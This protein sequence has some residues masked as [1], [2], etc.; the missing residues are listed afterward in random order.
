M[1]NVLYERNS[2]GIKQIRVTEEVNG[3]CVWIGLEP[4]KIYWSDGVIG[5]KKEDAIDYAVNLY[6]E[7]RH[8]D[9]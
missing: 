9:Q 2:E 5:S 6:K 1:K 4:Q 8:A 7:S 3:Y